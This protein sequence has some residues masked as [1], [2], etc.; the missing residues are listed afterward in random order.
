MAAEIKKHQGTISS[1]LNAK[2]FEKID[3][4]LKGADGVDI[5]VKMLHNA[6]E[7]HKRLGQELKINQFLSA[8]HHHESY[9]DIKNDVSRINNMLTE[10]E[11]QNIEIDKE[12]IAKVNHFSS[13]MISE[14]NLRKNRDLLADT[15]SKCEHDQVD[16]LQNLIEVA[17]KCKV[18]P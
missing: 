1:A 13:R 12:L 15:I 3:I 5:D 8:K 6:K 18:E 14:R 11:D 7:M 10:A 4:A 2:S 17:S 16:K 9:K